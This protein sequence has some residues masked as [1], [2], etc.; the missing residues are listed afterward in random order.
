MREKKPGSVDVHLLASRVAASIGPWAEEHAGTPVLQAIRS[1]VGDEDALVKILAKAFARVKVD[2]DEEALA[3]KLESALELRFVAGAILPPLVRAL[4]MR[5]IAEGALK[6][7]DTSEEL[8]VELLARTDKLAKAVG[9]SPIAKAEVRQARVALAD[10][11]RDLRGSYDSDALVRAVEDAVGIEWK[12]DVSADKIDSLV[13]K[14]ACPA[15]DASGHYRPGDALRH[16]KLG[17]GIVVCSFDSAVQVQFAS[18]TRKLAHRP[19]E[20]ALDVTQP[21][22]S[23]RSVKKEE[24]RPSYPDGFEI[25]RIPTAPFPEEEEEDEEEEDEPFILSR[26]F[27]EESSSPRRLSPLAQALTPL[28]SAL[29]ERE[30]LELSD[31]IS[32]ELAAERLADAL[33]E[34]NAEPRPDAIYEALLELDCVEEIYISESE[35]ARR[36]SE[37]AAKLRRGS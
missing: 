18:G 32:F 26:L 11:L 34:M 29:A 4:L 22:P 27:G 30:E 23:R 37:L 19:S 5:E 3:S 17:V 36:M 2:A 7:K 24:E 33:G 31:D 12:G 8:A 10:R 16:P 1:R 15:Y 25:K 21:E 28:L 9:A 35:L 13:G 6:G 20:A 14:R